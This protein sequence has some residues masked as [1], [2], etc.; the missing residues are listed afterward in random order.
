M[1]L[2]AGIIAGLSAGLPL[3]QES[4]GLARKC[5]AIDLGLALAAFSVE[6]PHTIH[7]GIDRDSFLAFAM[8]KGIPIAVGESKNAAEACVNRTPGNLIQ[9]MLRALAATRPSHK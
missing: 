9:Q 1:Y 5:G 7:P 3:V 6:S 2:L 8:K 4:T